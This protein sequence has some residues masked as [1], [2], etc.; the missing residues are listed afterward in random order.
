[1]LQQM[2][3]GLS[4]QEVAF[5]PQ[6][7]KAKWRLAPPTSGWEGG[8]GSGQG[9]AKHFHPMTTTCLLL[10]LTPIRSILRSTTGSTSRKLKKKRL[11]HLE[12]DR[13]SNHC[14]AFSLRGLQVPKCLCRFSPRRMG[15]INP[16]Q[17]G[18]LSAFPCFSHHCYFRFI[19]SF[20]PRPPAAT[21]TTTSLFHHPAVT[22]ILSGHPLRQNKHTAADSIDSSQRLCTN[23]LL[24]DRRPSPPPSFFSAFIFVNPLQI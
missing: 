3:Q 17:W 21:T 20:P 11:V 9:R 1:M 23:F 5:L 7:R 10:F 18:K 2:Q 13:S 19:I 6:N 15:E 24:I 14:P 22:R 4:K 12:C 8:P 16:T